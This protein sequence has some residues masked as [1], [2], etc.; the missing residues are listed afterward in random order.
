V[1]NEQEKECP[2]KTIVIYATKYGAAGEIAQRIANKIDGAAVCDLKRG[3]LPSLAEFDCV[4]IGSSVYAGMIR[5]EAKAFLIQNTNIL[6]EKK[7]GLF[8]SGMGE[9]GEKSY[10]EKN[11]PPDIL[12]S[13]KAASFLGGIFNP[14]KANFIERFIMKMITK[15]SRLVNNISDSKIEKF[16]ET[17]KA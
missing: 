6:R 8:V 10:F 5:K 13:A 3:S 14:D 17:M 4:I 9:S 12:Q 2:M 16:V 15:Q 7:L 11:F 1:L